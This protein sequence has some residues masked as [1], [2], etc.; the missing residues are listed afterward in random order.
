MQSLLSGTGQVDTLRH[1]R[2]CFAL[3]LL[4]SLVTLFEREARGFVAEA[5]SAAFFIFVGAGLVVASRIRCPE[6]GTRWFFYAIRAQP[7]G[8]WLFWLKRF[9]AC[10]RCGFSCH[11]ENGHGT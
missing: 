3:A 1:A 9:S 11:E 4:W 2:L 8:Q 7:V 10:P 6:C 5:A